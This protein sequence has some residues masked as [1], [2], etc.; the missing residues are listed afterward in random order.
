MEFRTIYCECVNQVWDYYL[1]NTNRKFKPVV[2]IGN[3]RQKILSRVYDFT[4]FDRTDVINQKITLPEDEMFPDIIVDELLHNEVLEKMYN[5][6]S[7]Q[8]RISPELFTRLNYWYFRLWDYLFKKY[9]VEAL[10]FSE[11]PHI[12]YSYAGY[13]LA[14]KRKIKVLYTATLPLN[15]ISYLVQDAKSYHYF[16][17]GPYLNPNISQSEQENYRN[18]I[19]SIYGIKKNTVEVNT[20]SFGLF[21]YHTLKNIIKNFFLNRK[22]YFAQIYRNDFLIIKS[23]R[24]HIEVLRRGIRKK[25]IRGFYQNNMVKSIDG[26]QKIKVIFALHYEPEMTLLPLAGDNY[27]QFKTIQKLSTWIGDKGNVYVKE[28]PWQLDYGKTRAF[29]RGLDFYKSLLKFKNI[30]L[31]D[32]EFDVIKEISKFDIISTITGTIGWEAFL[33]KKPVVVFSKSWYYG[34]P[35]VYNF[36]P[37]I[38]VEVL[39]K[40]TDYLK[41]I[42]DFTLIFDELNRMPKFSIRLTDASKDEFLKDSNVIMSL[43]NSVEC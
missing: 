22:H 5:R 16:K 1:Q 8:T 20:I 25:R 12:P 40:E 39:L 32:L 24:Y 28:H 4:F 41:G 26:G 33:L 29:E 18:K 38:S 3:E 36:E 9:R 10:I 43:L 30:K 37:S 11:T 27:D 34:V 6:N 31:L 7:F 42:I 21:F 17:K 2:W 13:L 23:Y 15:G 19:I 14:R 35:L